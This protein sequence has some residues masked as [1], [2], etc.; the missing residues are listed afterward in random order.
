MALVRSA[1]ARSTVDTTA[2]RF[3]PFCMDCAARI[4]AMIDSFTLAEGVAVGV[5]M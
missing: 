2:S 4:A 3:V 5:V 1:A